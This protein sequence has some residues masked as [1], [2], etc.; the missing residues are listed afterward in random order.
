MFFYLFR[1]NIFPHFMCIINDNLSIFWSGLCKIRENDVGYEMSHFQWRV[2]SIMMI[3]QLLNLGIDNWTLHADWTFLKL[4]GGARWINSNFKFFKAR[5]YYKRWT[6]AK[7]SNFS[8]KCLRY[9]SSKVIWTMAD[10][11]HV[12]RFECRGKGERSLLCLMGE[13]VKK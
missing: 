12:D 9:H 11:D 10:C 4:M 2:E 5:K 3:G 8:S 1:H 7:I 6:E 13:Q